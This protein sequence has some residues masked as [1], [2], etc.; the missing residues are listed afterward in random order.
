[1]PQQC[2]CGCIRR[3]C[4]ST[5][6]AR[7]ISA[8]HHRKSFKPHWPAWKKRN[9]RHWPLNAWWMNSSPAHCRQSLRRCYRNC[10]M[11]PTA[12]VP[13]PRPW[14]PP[15][16]HPGCPRRS[17]WKSAAQSAIPTNT[18]WA[19]FSSNTFRAAQTFPRVRHPW[20]RPSSQLPMSA[21]FP[22]MTR[23][24]RKST[25]RFRSSST[26][27]AACASAFTLPPRAWEL[28]LNPIS[29][30]LRVRAC[31]PCICRDG[32]LRCCPKT[33]SNT[34]HSPPGARCLRYR[35][36]SMSPATCE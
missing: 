7:A 8:A 11:R 26:P 22:S 6:R 23:I 30:A 15:V 10:S 24:R 4:I 19:A 31:P 17:C 25:M 5:A 34:S 20:T 13:R 9:S 35:F 33:W 14:K 12:I 28:R 3:Q 32:K 16:Q 21:R 18:I 27:T 29:V 36:I 1:M 2:C